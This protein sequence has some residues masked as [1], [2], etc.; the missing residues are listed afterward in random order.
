MSPFSRKKL[1]GGE[2]DDNVHWVP[3]IALPVP[4][5]D[6]PSVVCVTGSRYS[7]ENDR[8]SPY[9]PVE[10]QVE[11]MELYGLA[12]LLQTLGMPLMSVK[13]VVN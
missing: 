9:F 12:V 4:D 10:G 7:T 3:P 11:D 8:K 5:V 6:L 1:Y 13:F 2:V